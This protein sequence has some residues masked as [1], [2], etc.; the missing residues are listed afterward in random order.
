M[1]LKLP[2]LMLATL[3]AALASSGRAGIAG[4]AVECWPAIEAISSSLPEL[5]GSDARQSWRGLPVELECRGRDVGKITVSWRAGAGSLSDARSA[6]AAL[7]SHLTADTA[8]AVRGALDRCVTAAGRSPG[9]QRATSSR[10]MVTCRVGQDGA[11][12][13]VQ[14]RSAE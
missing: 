4:A 13:T 11:E 14:S 6:I 9:V 3:V 5:V 2:R 12:F 7:G 8:T 10:S 1:P